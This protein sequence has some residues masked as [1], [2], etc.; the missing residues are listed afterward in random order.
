MTR[1]EGRDIRGVKRKEKTLK[2]RKEEG[3]KL[4]RRKGRDN[5]GK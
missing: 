2:G 5:E 3:D 4:E 1:S